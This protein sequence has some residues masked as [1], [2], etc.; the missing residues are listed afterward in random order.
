MRKRLH[1]IVRGRVQ[2]VGFRY[3]VVERA[4]ALGLSGW[5]RNGND[6]ATVE[7]LAEG[8][9][10]ALRRLEAAL[11]EGPRGARVDDLDAQW[12]GEIEGHE[13]FGVR[14]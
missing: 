2:M 11:R 6:G 12:S 1:A 5:V 10:D 9:E 8:P 3:F 14:W 13:G 4:R 7:V